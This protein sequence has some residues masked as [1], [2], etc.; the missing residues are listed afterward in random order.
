MEADST[1]EAKGMLCT[2]RYLQSGACVQGGQSALKGGVAVVPGSLQSCRFCLPHYAHL[3]NGSHVFA[4]L[5][6]VVQ[7]QLAGQ[8]R[9]TLL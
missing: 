4:G 3:Q 2:S 1:G 9:G 8:T 6:K 5:H 7:S